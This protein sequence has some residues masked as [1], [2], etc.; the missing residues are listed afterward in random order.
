MSEGL[1][2]DWIETLLGVQ[3]LFTTGDLRNGCV[4]MNLAYD[5]N[6]RTMGRTINSTRSTATLYYIV[7]LLIVHF[8]DLK[9]WKLAWA[10]KVSW[11]ISRLS[12]NIVSLYLLIVSPTFWDLKLAWA[13]KQRVWKTTFLV[14]IPQSTG[15]IQLEE[16]PQ[17]VNQ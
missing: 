1:P 13:L 5:F 2:Y 16:S 9:Q 11:N 14:N 12:C 4:L 15:F 6:I 8:W 10:L 17:F 3:L 7:V